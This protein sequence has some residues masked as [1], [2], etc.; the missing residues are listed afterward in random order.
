MLCDF[1]LGDWLADASR[2]ARKMAEELRFGRKPLTSLANEA[3]QRLSAS[4][5]SA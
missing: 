4:S 3:M 5:N 2:Q 1:F